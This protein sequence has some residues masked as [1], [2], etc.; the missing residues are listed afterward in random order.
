MIWLLLFAV[1]FIICV[2]G[3]LYLCFSIAKL[4][5]IR[6]LT[7]GRKWLARL[8]SLV[9]ITAVFV[10]L[11]AGLSLLDAATALIHV[12]FFFCLTGII[13]KVNA[14]LRQREP[15]ISLQAALTIVLSI[16]YLALG[17]YQCINVWETNY[18]LSSDKCSA[19]VRIAMIADVHLGT[20]FDG[21]GFAKHVDTIMSHDPDYLMIV[22][23]FV[24][25]DTRR[26]DMIRACEAL[27]S[28]NPKHGVWYVYGN[29][30]KGY[31][32]SRDFSERDLKEALHD[33]G[34]HVLADDVVCEGQLCLVGRRD[35]MTMARMDIDTL[36]QKADTSKYTVILNHE[37]TD[38]ANESSTNADLVLS[39]H[40]HGGQI[41]P[42]GILQLILK[43]NDKV[44]GCEVKNGTSFIVTSGISDWALHFK[45]GTRSEYVIIDIGRH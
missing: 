28:A 39:G 33:N 4:E 6:R 11:S 16:S 13:L 36:M 14:K 29:H 5:C 10:A 37:P 25:D 19:P 15:S 18:V 20:T 7:T 8:I 9:I 21:E 22:G 35:G 42:I 43:Q 23:D 41:I 12:V 31:F 26:D 38:Y 34:V 17:Y 45:T 44:Y 24:D 32:S 1:I 2:A 30:D 27:G 40:T 3:A